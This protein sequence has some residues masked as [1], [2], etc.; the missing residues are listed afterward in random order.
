MKTAVVNFKT[1]PEIKKRAMERAKMDGV[2]LSFLLNRRL[3]E[4]AGVKSA[5]IDFGYENQL[6]KDAKDKEIAKI[7]KEEQDAK[8]TKE[9]ELTKN[10]KKEKIAKNAKEIETKKVKKSKSEKSTK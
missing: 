4:I 9:K 3:H 7:A 6:A 1:T 2:P 8:N 5:T 10:A